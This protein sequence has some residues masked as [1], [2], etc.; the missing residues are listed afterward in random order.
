MGEFAFRGKRLSLANRVLAILI[1]QNLFWP[2]HLGALDLGQFDLGQRVCST[3]ANSTLANGAFIR[4]PK[5][6][7][8]IYSIWAKIPPRPHPPVFCWA[9]TGH[10][11]VVPRWAPKGGSP[12]SGEPKISRFFFP[13][14]PQFSSFFSLLGVLLW[15]FGGV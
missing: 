8:E 12:K 2:I 15:N 9:N 11:K 1:C 6:S 13:L 14:P 7:Q 10:A 5:K 4:L 3:L